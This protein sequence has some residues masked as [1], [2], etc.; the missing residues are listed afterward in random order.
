VTELE[1]HVVTLSNALKHLSHMAS[2][3]GADLRLALTSAANALDASPAQSLAE[4][5][6]HA[7]ESLSEIGLTASS[8]E[9]SAFFHHFTEFD[10]KR[11]TDY[12]S[13]LRA[14]ADEQ[15]S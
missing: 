11:M 1:A 15:Q 7:I 4:I 8:G 10:R 3:S 5:Q 14:K 9:I 12:A 6:A 2:T 13:A